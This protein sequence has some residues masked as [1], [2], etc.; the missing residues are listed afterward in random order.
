MTINRERPGCAEFRHGFSL[1]ELLLVVSILLILTVLLDRQ[2]STSHDRRTLLACQGNLQKV[3]LA[4]SLYAN[5]NRGNFPIRT[6][7]SR[8]EMPLSLLVPRSTTETS[9][10]ICPGSDD[11]PIPEAEPF[12]RQQISYAYYMGWTTTSGAGQVIATDWQVNSAPKG[13]GQQI[14]S[15]DGKG[16]GNNHQKHGG[17]FVLIGGQTISSGPKTPR[18]LRFP[19]PVLLLNPKP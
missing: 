12:D 16:P 11:K 9:I 8:S 2:F 18:D 1:L 19:S 3:Y 6:G 4:L 7:A 10:F 13:A 5:D 17:N 14:F 15:E